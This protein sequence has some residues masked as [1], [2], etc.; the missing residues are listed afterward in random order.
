[1]ARFAFQ[2]CSLQRWIDSRVRHLGRTDPRQA[3]LPGCEAAHAR[4]A[5]WGRWHVD[6]TNT[7]LEHSGGC[8]SASGTGAGS[9]TMWRCWPSQAASRSAGCWPSTG[10]GTPLQD[11]RSQPGMGA[12]LLRG[13]PCGK[14][15]DV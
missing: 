6:L 11:R 7:T 5:I 2:A 9:R 4:R 15:L 13:H 12:R 14:H 3:A 1:M 8:W 10:A